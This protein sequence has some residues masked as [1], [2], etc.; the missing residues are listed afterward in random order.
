MTTQEII[1]SGFFRSFISKYVDYNCGYGSQARDTL[2]YAL[3]ETE[4]ERKAATL[5]EMAVIKKQI[6]ELGHEDMSIYFLTERKKVKADDYVQRG[7]QGDY[8]MEQ[9]HLYFTNEMSYGLS[10]IITANQEIEKTQGEIDWENLDEATSLALHQFQSKSEDELVLLLESEEEIMSQVKQ[11]IELFQK[12]DY[13][14]IDI[15]FYEVYRADNE[16]LDLLFTISELLTSLFRLEQFREFLNYSEQELLVDPFRQ[17]LEKLGFFELPMIKSLP[18]DA[19]QKL[20][21]LLSFSKIPYLMAFFEY[22]GFLKHLEALYST[23]NK[24]YENI[25]KSFG[26]KFRNVKGNILTLNPYSEENRKIYTAW[27][28]KERVAED[29]QR[30]K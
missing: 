16:T 24:I 26:L 21:N 3:C 18:A 30:L 2:I 9:F 14:E 19:E 10:P 12:E 15:D 6:R 8:L 23:K 25:A 5:D 4:E 22:V 28:H 1:E 29:Y 17:N 20:L 27:L 11:D 13:W 7:K